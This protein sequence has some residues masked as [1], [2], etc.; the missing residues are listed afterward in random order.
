MLITVRFAKIDH[1]LHLSMIARSV[2]SKVL[3]GVCYNSAMDEFNKLMKGD[4]TPINHPDLGQFFEPARVE[5][6]NPEIYKEF[7]ITC[8][9]KDIS[10]SQGINLALN[11]WLD[12]K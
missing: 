3:A 4:L 2:T 1:G 11:N 12:K 8:L 9:Q 5:N 10:L 6:I 7:K